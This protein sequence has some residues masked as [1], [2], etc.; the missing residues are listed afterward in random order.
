VQLPAAALLP[1][2]RRELHALDPEVALVDP[3]TLGELVDDSIFVERMIAILSG[4]FGGLALLL[5]AI[6]IYGVMAYAVTRRTAEIGLR[7]ALGAAPARIEWM[8]LRD[9]LWLIGLGA[10]IGLPLSLAASRIT[11]SLLY[12]I[13][14]N[15]PLA[16]ILTLA[17]LLV[18][19][20]L[21]AFLP[22]HRA[23]AVEPVDALRHE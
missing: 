4:F 3:R 7:I 8:V 18:V 15:D 6:G 1:A 2:I 9:G 22:A 17:V 12:G 19:G 14:P 11:A 13:K 21:A 16:F 23:A 5:A 20:I 10:V